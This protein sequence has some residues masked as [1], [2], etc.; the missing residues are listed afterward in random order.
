MRTL[1]I[2]ATGRSGSVFLHGLFD[3]HPQVL[4]YPA[5]HG[6]Y[7]LFFPGRMESVE[8]VREYVE[9]FTRLRVHFEGL[10][11]ESLGKIGPEGDGNF[12]LE[13]ERYLPLLRGEL[14]SRLRALRPPGG[15]PRDSPRLGALPT[16][17][18]VDGAAARG[19][20]PQPVAAR[21]RPRR[22]PRRI[23]LH[24]IR[25]PCAAYYAMI[26]LSNRVYG[27]LKPDFFY[28]FT[29]HVFADPWK[30]LQRE[31]PGFAPGRYRVLRIEDLNADGER[32][33]RELAGW[34][35]LDFHTSLLQ[36]TVAGRPCLGEQRIRKARQRF[37]RHGEG[38]RALRPL[39]RLEISGSSRCSGARW[40]RTVSP[41]SSA[42]GS[43]CAWGAWL[44]WRCP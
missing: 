10:Y 21:P 9:L 3:S 24:T 22:L 23:C 12:H 32:T 17:G 29:K 8:E 20:R 25:E 26:D 15:G 37:L 38:G 44:R 6:V 11:D 30:S 39:G 41:V 40:R 43:R 34:L 4:S 2:L 36:S 13:R 5:I 35:G 33:M 27:Y 1:F 28:G 18:P 14:S 19:A 7:S 31:Y 42:A 16:P